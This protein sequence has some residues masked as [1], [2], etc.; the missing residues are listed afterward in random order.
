MGDAKTDKLNCRPGDLARVVGVEAATGLADRF[1]RLA[2]EAPHLRGGAWYWR[3]APAILCTP[4]ANCHRADGVIVPAGTTV[5]IDNIA[6]T[7]LRPVRD[8]GPDAVDEILQR[9][10]APV[11]TLLGMGDDA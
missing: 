6:D 11:G 1:V 8:P 9:I 2:D 10:G 5:S 7:H 4:L 3:L